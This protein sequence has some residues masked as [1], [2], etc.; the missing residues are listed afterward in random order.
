MTTLNC[1]ARWVLLPTLLLVVSC[2]TIASSGTS[3]QSD[4]RNVMRVALKQTCASGPYDD[5][6]ES[7]LGVVALSVIPPLVESG[8]RGIGSAI[9]KAGE[10]KTF[11]LSGTDT[12]HFYSID[13]R[14]Q[15][16]IL[17]PASTCLIVFRGKVGSDGAGDLE[18]HEF[19]GRFASKLNRD[20]KLVAPP[21]FYYEAYLRPAGDGTAFKLEPK[22]VYYGNRIG[23][24]RRDRELVM[25]ISFAP[26]AK[27]IGEEEAFAIF[28]T[29][30]VR[31]STGQLNEGFDF[32]LQSYQS[33]YRTLPKASGVSQDTL[34][35][36]TTGSAQL[37]TYKEAL[38]AL[39]R[40][41]D[42]EILVL[43]GR[44]LDLRS[45]RLSAI[46]MARRALDEA[47]LA[48]AGSADDEEYRETIA[49]LRRQLDEVRREN[50]LATDI[51][52]TEVHIALRR[53]VVPA[54]DQRK[55]LVGAIAKLEEQLRIARESL[56]RSTP[57]NVTVTLVESTDANRVLV[58]IGEALEGAADDVK[59]IVVAS[60][61][62]A[63]PEAELAKTVADLQNKS[64]LRTEAITAG[65]AW[66]KA[67][68][69]YDVADEQSQPEKLSNLR[70]QYLAAK[71]K[72]DIAEASG[73]VEPVC[74]A[75]S[76][77]P[78]GSS[79]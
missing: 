54:T 7:V 22:L 24:N 20:L 17:N 52:Q 23:P 39:D 12:M 32:Q 68:N 44:L 65:E 16:F 49:G 67:R 47:R 35:A 76:I 66:R 15:S 31:P 56:S 71:L 64:A 36:Y 59:E 6:F 2:K 9:K 34:I 13:G 70:V 4:Q 5:E 51:R 48:L 27:T 45:E 1:W 21:D 75:L 19:F 73:V 62:P 79:D 40:A 60:L 11:S 58:A 30:F 53:Q 18:K 25:T 38:M 33:S 28:S 8:I 57:V 14:G 50:E 74:F 37:E 3:E 10:A 77:P 26:P 43:E 78:D 61:T 46:A 63:D 72:C 69:A 42:P 41:E 55:G 29:T